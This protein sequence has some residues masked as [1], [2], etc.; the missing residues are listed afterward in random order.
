MTLQGAMIWDAGDQASPT[1]VAFRKTG[2]YQGS[3]L[4]DRIKE[5]GPL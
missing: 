2:V 3:G 4:F 5:A 1:S